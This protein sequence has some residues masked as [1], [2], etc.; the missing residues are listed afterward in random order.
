VKKTRIRKKP[1]A[2]QFGWEAGTDPDNPTLVAIV[3]GK[4]ITV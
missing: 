2:L 3:P 4:I 1:T